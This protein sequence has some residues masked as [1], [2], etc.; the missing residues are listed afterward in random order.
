MFLD[1]SAADPSGK[2]APHAGTVILRALPL[3][4]SRAHGSTRRA[5]RPML[6]R[7]TRPVLPDPQ[8]QAAVD[9]VSQTPGAAA[10][11]TRLPAPEPQFTRLLTTYVTAVTVIG[12]GLLAF[13]LPLMRLEQPL[14]FLALRLEFRVHLGLEG[15]S[16]ACERQC[17]AVDVVLHR[18]HGARAAR[19]R[20]SHDR[21]G[22]QRATQCLL[23]TRG[24]VSLRQTAF[25]VAALV[26]RRC[27][28]RARWHRHSADS[29]SG[30]TS[31][32]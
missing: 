18:L 10:V 28:P 9:Q 23:S 11:T 31:C 15:P 7:A 2:A 5:P 20:R 19:T 4:N 8:P 24:R 13:R 16:A 12:L 32:A 1:H 22:C 6:A 26:T 29:T 21:G 17:N 14:L 3:R 27:R 30:K 25:S